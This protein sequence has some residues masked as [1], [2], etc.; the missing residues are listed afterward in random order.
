[1]TTKSPPWRALF[2]SFLRDCGQRWARY[3]GWWFCREPV[4]PARE[5]PGAVQQASLTQPRVASA[6]AESLDALFGACALR[7]P[8]VLSG[9][10][11]DVPGLEAGEDA[12]GAVGLGLLGNTNGPR[13]PQAASPPRQPHIAVHASQLRQPCTD[14]GW[15][16]AATLSKDFLTMLPSYRP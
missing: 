14:Q 9:H 4:K 3:C 5:T 8:A 15:C 1:M 10:P 6:P 7:T 11:Q 12:G 16:R 2:L 13:C